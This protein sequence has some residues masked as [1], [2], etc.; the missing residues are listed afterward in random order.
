MLPISQCKKL[1]GKEFAGKPNE[2]IKE[3]RDHFYSLAYILIEHSNKNKLEDK[4]GEQKK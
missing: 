4:N 3:I 1:L 2:K